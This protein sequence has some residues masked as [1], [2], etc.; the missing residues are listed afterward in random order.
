MFS[1]GHGLAAFSCWFDDLTDLTNVDWSAVYRRYW[2]DTV[3]DPDRQ[4]RKQAEFL[5]HNSCDWGLINEIGVCSRSAQSRVV[6]ILNSV[7]G[8]HQPVVNVQP[9]WYYY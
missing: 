7:S 3:N 9:N 2:I 8:I 1:D 5:V 6:N 4:R